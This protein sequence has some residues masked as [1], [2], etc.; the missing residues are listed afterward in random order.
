SR[1]V[2]GNTTVDDNNGRLYTFQT[3]RPVIPPYF[4]NFESGATNWQVFTSDE[5]QSSWTLGVPNNG[6]ETAAHSP[7]LAWGS[8]IN[9]AN[10]D[11]ID[12]FLISPPID[13]TGGNSATLSFWTSYDFSQKTDTDI[14][15]LGE[16]M[17]ITN[18]AGSPIT[19][20]DYSDASGGWYTEQVDLTPYVGN[21]VYLVWYHSLFAFDSAP[22]P[23]W[24]IDDV[25]VTLTN[26]PSGTI[27]VSN[28]IA[29]A[30][31]VL[32]GPMNRAG[33]GYMVFTNVIPGQYVVT[34]GAV[35]FYQTPPA[36]TNVLNARS[37]LLFGGNYTFP[38]ANNT[39]ISDSWEQQYFGG[40]SPTLTRF[41]DSDGVGFTYYA[42]VF[43][44]TN[45]A[46]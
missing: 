44:G 39:G 7:Q 42:E 45:P 26:L 5:S 19:V 3:L 14:Y 29:E 38:D 35:A 11:T 18:N 12:T 8:S 32:N 25:S 13:L 1:D 27:V 40:V 34:F 28:N 31:F 43:V 6:V 16:L 20:Q 4:D 10:L 33:R 9:G 23:G 15:D 30:N 17:I 2:A 37:T 41:T 46:A 22:R 21:V 24:L 36:Q